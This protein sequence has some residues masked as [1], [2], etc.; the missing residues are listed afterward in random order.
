MR[1]NAAVFEKLFTPLAVT[2]VEIDAPRPGEAMVKIVASGVCHTDALARDG[3]MPF[4][5]PGV[6]GHEG[7]GVVAAVGDGVTSVSVG[8]K[9]V[10]GWPWC[11]SCRNCL[12]GQPRYCLQLGPLVIS[13]SRADG[14][15]ALRRL[16]GS[17]LHSHFFGQSS[18]A[19]QA[20]CAANALV[21]VPADA[22]VSVL[23]PLACGISTG[24]GA[25]LNALRP[26]AGSSIVI[27]GS[28]A[29][30]LSAVMAARLTGATHIIAV[31]RLASRLSLA[32]ELGATETIDVS[33]GADPVAA[34]HEICGGPADF[35]LDCA[36]N[37][38]VLRQA[39]DS[40]GMRGTVALIGGAPAGAAFSLD[41]MSTLWG[42]TVVGVLGGEGRSVSLI[43][44][45]ITLNA[46]GRFP[47]ERLIEKFP[48]D[49]V[50]EALE[51]SHRGDV[52]KPVLIMPE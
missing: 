1:V 40:V 41:H 12:E 35:S 20:I 5:A 30:G 42:K 36:G 39:A 29:V 24:A 45:L 8:D 15:T 47:Y 6:L 50:N 2:E 28:G 10:I 48:L 38:N 44:T 31:D 13:G 49:Q 21:P 11:G 22:D 51:A 4:P 19:S 17:P 14:S 43:N 27:Y 3:D 46:Q 23:G 25:V 32:A 18:F 9:V 37:V 26:F 52:I 16:D 7:A 34:V 33:G